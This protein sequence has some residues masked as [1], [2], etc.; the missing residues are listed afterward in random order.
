MAATDQ[1]M[2][3]R[4][5]HRQFRLDNGLTLLVHEDRSLP[6]LAVNLWYRVG[7]GHES[8]GRTGFAHLFEHLMFEGSAHVPAG[9]F[10]HLLEAVGG[11]NNGSTSTDRTNY[12]INAPTHALELALWL[13]SDRMGYLL[14]TM[15]QAK[16]DLQRD[17]VMNERRQ[18][19]E[20]RPYGLAWETLVGNLFPLGH[21]YHH[22][23]I[24]SM[25]D[26]EAA[27]LEDVRAFF[28]TWY[29]PNNATLAIAGDV[30]A[31]RAHDV[32][33]RWFGD[34]PAGAPV[35][36]AEL[37]PIAGP[38]DARLVMEDSVQLPR[39]YLGWRS[40]AHY[41]EADADME[42]LAAVLA[43]GKSARLYQRL[44]YDEQIAQDVS[45]FQSG[46]AVDGTFEIVVTAKPD[47]A[48]PA[49]EDVVREELARVVVAGIG[50]DEMERALA[51][52]EAG[53]VQAL[54]R[55]GGFGGKADR[56]NEY[57]VFAGD[58]DFARRDLARFQRATPASVAEAARRHLIEHA[59]VTL[60]VVPAGRRDL[61]A[62]A[63]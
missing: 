55:G 42:M 38:R 9:A 59:G 7:S 18:S 49:I 27:S 53:F 36:R 14:E 20:N 39:L 6:L 58:A 41:T 26:L 13:E 63:A 43:D 17:V 33:Q 57:L 8:P 4:I 56:L 47:V 21:P 44:V 2:D 3:V 50:S 15:T 46:A 51:Q 30:D 23:V 61:A 1:Q 28:R 31:E 5:Q 52:V 10:D 19:Y 34:L 35:P 24:G 54:E 45:V 48:L 32:V 25:A 60:S 22:P 40:P 11:T 37:P 62:E 29:A 12:W 16:L